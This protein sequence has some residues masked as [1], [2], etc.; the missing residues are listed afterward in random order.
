MRIVAGTARGRR[1]EAPPGRTTRPTSD[2]MREALFS[3]LTAMRGALSGARFLDL[4]AGSGAVGLEALSRGAASAV[5]VESDR[6]VLRVLRSNVDEL[7]L[8]GAVIA[9][10]LRKFVAEPAVPSRTHRLLDRRTPPPT[11]SRGPRRTAARRRAYRPSDRGGRAGEPRR[12]LRLAG[13]LLRRTVEALRRGKPLV[14][15]RRDGDRRIHRRRRMIR[16][17]CPGSFDPVTNGHLDIIGRASVLYDE[18][19]VAVLINKSKSC[20]TRRRTR[21][22]GET[23]EYGKSPSSVHG[24]SSTSARAPH[25]ASSRAASRSDLRYALQRRR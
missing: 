3:T 12:R 13:R 20:S 1:L 10:A 21:A 9:R 23:G 15:S 11:D 7:G 8:A 2:R 5:L 4:Y 17:V 19:V 25:P 22:A 16:V 18:V 14:R 6:S 24:L